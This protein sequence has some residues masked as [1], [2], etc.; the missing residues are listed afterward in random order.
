MKIKRRIWGLLGVLIFVASCFA[1]LGNAVVANAAAT[2]VGV[3]IYKGAYDTMPNSIQNT[4]L[5][6][7]AWHTANGG[8][9]LKDV[10]FTVYDATSKFYSLAA[11]DPSK[12]V[13]DLRD[14]IAQEGESGLTQV[15]SEQF[16]DAVGHTKF[17]LPDKVTVNGVEKDAVYLIVETT[18]PATVTVKADNL[19]VVFPVYEMN[20]DGTPTATAL[21]EIFLYPKNQQ[22]DDI[23]VEKKKEVKD[24]FTVGEPIEYNITFKVPAG[25]DGL[26]NSDQSNPVYRYTQFFLRDESQANLHYLDNQG[27]YVL[28]ADNSLTPITDVDYSVVADPSGTPVNGGYSNIFHVFFNDAD[29]LTNQTPN[30]VQLGQYAEKTL[31]F[32]YRMYLDE[33]TTPDEWI[34]NQAT[35]SYEN[36]P[37]TGLETLPWTGDD[38][39]TY[40]RRFK[41][42]DQD[43]GSS[44]QGAKFVVKR[45]NDGTIEYM[46]AAA[47]TTSPSRWTT[48]IDEA[49]ELSS[50]ASGLFTVTGLE[51]TVSHDAA[52][53][54]LN[55]TVSTEMSQGDASHPATVGQPLVQYWLEETQAPSNEYVTLTK[56]IPFTVDYGTYS[57]TINVGQETQVENKRKG[58]LPG[59]GGKGIYGIIAVGTVAVLAVGI[60]LLRNKETAED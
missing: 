40:G 56:D 35:L 21:S 17:A 26:A 48:N 46:L 20:A 8:R 50:D 57:Q 24:D 60:Y 12:S 32:K 6:D 23:S 58:T 34:D 30:V 36:N 37:G 7:E 3:N 27:L 2:D 18:S 1:G 13:N 44:L 47:T 41:K 51:G 11:S 49:L 42:V 9:P 16:T 22:K 19:V 4:G 53:N 14:Q 43:N 29:S 54:P 28:E 38:V 15:G 59:T 31:V 5:K 10:G 39:I 45:E 33:N 55:L 52:G 25:I